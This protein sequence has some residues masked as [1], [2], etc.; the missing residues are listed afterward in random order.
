M[1][2][3]LTLSEYLIQLKEVLAILESKQEFEMCIE[4]RNLFT[5]IETKNVKLFIDTKFDIKIMRKAKFF[6]K[7][8][9]YDQMA[10]RVKI[11]FGLDSIFEYANHGEGMWCP[12]Y[13]Y[14]NEMYDIY[15]KVEF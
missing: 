10:E 4:I 12:Y 14:A 8:D 1:D 6:S 11:F 13:R 5:A 15:K 3:K 9:T 2:R 7:T